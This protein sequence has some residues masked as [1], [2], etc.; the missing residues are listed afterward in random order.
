MDLK[1]VKELIQILE[2]SNLN[3]LTIKEKNGIEITLEK[4]HAS[5]QVTHE[6]PSAPTIAPAPA[7]KPAKHTVPIE[8]ENCVK[9]PMVGTF[10]R[11]ESPDSKSFAEVGEEV[12]VGS[13]LCIIEAMKVMNEIKSDRRGKVK[14]ILVENGKPV[15]FGQPLFV[16]E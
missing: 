2:K 8:V 10:Y 6:Y 3:R 5:P 14:E 1:Y 9:S 13:P 7:P 4:G 11:S 16:I 12:N 15:E